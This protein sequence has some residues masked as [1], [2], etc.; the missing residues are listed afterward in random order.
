[1]SVYRKSLFAILVVMVLVLGACGGDK[2]AGETS[3]EQALTAAVGTAMQ[4]LTETAAAQPTAT[5]TP[6]EPPPTETPVPTETPTVTPTNPFAETLTA[7]P[8]AD[9]SAGVLPSPTPPPAGDLPCYRAHL[10]YESIPDG[11]EIPI[12]KRFTKVWRL[13]NTGACTWNHNFSLVWMSGDLLGADAV[14]QLTTED[15]DTW[16]H[17][18]LE[19]QMKAPGTPGTYKGYWMLRSDTGNVFG[20]GPDGKGWFWVEIKVYDPDPD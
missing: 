16:E 15:I 2:G 18:N 9:Q 4:G 20:I 7:A 12:E 6:E 17:L 10:D 14:I 8:T 19:V 1:M 3:P 5:A 13:K 11:T